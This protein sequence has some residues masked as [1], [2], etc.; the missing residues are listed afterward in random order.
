MDISSLVG[1]LMSAD[2][3]Q[4]IGK[5]TK[6]NKS[7]VTNVLAAA[8]PS[9][10][11]GAKEQSADTSTGFADALLSHGKDD[12][13][14][15]S[16]FLNKV[17]L[18]DGGKIIGHLLGSNAN[19]QV[20]TISQNTGVSKKDTNNILSA[21]APLLMSLL[22]QQAAS[23][24]SAQQ[25]SASA[26]NNAASSAAI[27]TAASLLLSNMDVS[28][29]LSGLLGGGNSQAAAQ[30]TTQNNTKDEKT[31]LGGVLGLLGKLLK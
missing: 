13:S 23:N 10:L 6:T 9:L 5:A 11:N 14:N 12:T 20:N 28:S 31:G 19:A 18:D 4:N 29:L 27:G 21:A 22:G 26:N 7:A 8:L 16:S 24:A 3:V 17:D 2:S 30:T 1:T 25:S 15:L